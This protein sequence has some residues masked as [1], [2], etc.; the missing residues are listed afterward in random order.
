MH[1]LSTI[2]LNI[3]KKNLDSVFSFTKTTQDEV[4]KVFSGFKNQ[5]KI[6]RRVWNL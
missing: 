2:I 6:V 1:T 3:K 5:K 4:L